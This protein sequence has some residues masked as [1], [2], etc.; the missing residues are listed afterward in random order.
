M[1]DKTYRRM[2][3]GCQC[4]HVARSAAEEARHRHNFPALCR[5]PKQKKGRATNDAGADDGKQEGRAGG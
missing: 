3:W 4:G 2:T 1:D 5:K